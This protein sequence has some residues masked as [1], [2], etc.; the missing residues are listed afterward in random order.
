MVWISFC[1]KYSCFWHL[2]DFPL[3]CWHGFQSAPW[4]RWRALLSTRPVIS[5]RTA[6]SLP[7]PK[8]LPCR[9]S[10]GAPT[11]APSL[12]QKSLPTGRSCAWSPARGS[13]SVKTLAEVW[14]AGHKERDGTLQGLTAS[15][16]LQYGGHL[17]HPLDLWLR[18]RHTPLLP[19]WSS[20]LTGGQQGGSRCFSPL[21][22]L[23]F[24]SLVI[25]LFFSFLWL[26]TIGIYRLTSTIQNPKTGSL[27]TLG[28]Y[29][30]LYPP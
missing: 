25:P 23:H 26:S 4:K 5:R 8:V 14:A 1:C 15:F 13:E 16:L 20:V 17:H 3:V 9:R 22:E 27:A 21:K 24:S 18:N 19:P 11:R 28:L 6:D 12:K 10:T 30:L 29:A 7:T 2:V